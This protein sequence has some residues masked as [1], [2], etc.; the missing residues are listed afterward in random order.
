MTNPTLQWVD[1][2]GTFHEWYHIL[3]LLDGRFLGDFRI[4]PGALPSTRYRR[5]GVAFFCRICG[6]VW[7]LWVARNSREEQQPFDIEPV[8]CEKHY[9]QWRLA[10]SL[11][12]AQGSDELLPSLPPAVLRREFILHHD[13][14]QKETE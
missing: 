1:P 9:D 5:S 4:D 3:V 11:L 7:G 12:P 10:G 6:R 14:K 2:D 8:S 13:K